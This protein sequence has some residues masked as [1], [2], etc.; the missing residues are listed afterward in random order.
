MR[1]VSVGTNRR[2]CCDPTASQLAPPISR[3][4]NRLQRMSIHICTGKTMHR[5]VK[6]R[7]RPSS[8]HTA[9]VVIEPRSPQCQSS[10]KATHWHCHCNTWAWQANGGLVHWKISVNFASSPWFHWALDLLITPFLMVLRSMVLLLWKE[11][12]YSASPPPCCLPTAAIANP[13]HCS[14]A[15]FLSATQLVWHKT[16]LTQRSVLY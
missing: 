14:L 7:L 4:Q 13:S 1:F 6:W 8:K 5:R 11:W 16:Q 15:D 9:Q 2:H 12:I 10:A 3:S